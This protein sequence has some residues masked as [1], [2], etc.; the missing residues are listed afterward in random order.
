MK[1]LITGSGGFIGCHLAR[2]LQVRGHIVFGLDTGHALVPEWLR[3]ERRRTSSAP[4]IRCDVRNRDSLAAAVASIAPDTVV[5]LAAIAGVAGAEA[6]PRAYSEVNVKGV[7]NLICACLDSN[8]RRI[9]HASSSSV[10]GEVDGAVS[11]DK[12]LN[13]LGQYGL[14][15]VLAERLLENIAEKGDMSVLILRPFSVIG[16]MGRPD[17]APWRFAEKLMKSEPIPI[18]EGASRDFT[19]VSDIA[20]A[21]A[22]AAEASCEGHH[23]VN[24]GGGEPR[25]AVELA[26]EIARGLGRECVAKPHPLPAYMPRST[27]ADISKAA[28]LLGWVPKKS[29]ADAV[30]DFSHWYLRSSAWR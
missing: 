24:V 8:V 1:V 17:M 22:L 20:N 16:P 29:F 7:E 30:A 27:H 5:H 6:D 11:E 15:K 4:E 13:P 2:L 26:N 12:A 21:F 19:S 23:A 25:S 28:R 9:V 14:T 18:H 3:D 10:Y